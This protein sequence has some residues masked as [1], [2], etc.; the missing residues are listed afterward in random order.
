MELGKYNTLKIAR[1]TSIGLYLEDQEGNDVLLPKKWAPNE[2]AIGD[3]IEV[4]IYKDAEERPIATTIKPLI[5]LHQ[6]AYLRAKHVSTVGAFMDWGLEKDLFVPFIEQDKRMVEGN[7]YLVYL[8]KDEMTDRLTASSKIHAYVEKDDIKLSPGQEVDII[9]AKRTDLGYNVIINHTY[10]GLLY[11]NEVFKRLRIGETH[12]AY[13]KQIR[14]DNKIDLSLEK[15]GYDKVEPN[16]HTVLTLLRKNNGFL[17][18]H[19]KSDP[20]EISK[21]L[22]MSKKTFK[23]AVGSLYKQQIIRIAEDGIHLL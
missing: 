13:V 12:K 3:E 8:Y 6:F 7:K 20:D 21:R 23:K 22:G 2:S 16:V 17:N 4:F 1:E 19:D 15:V 9:V 14:S 5:T 11:E 10:L 18:L